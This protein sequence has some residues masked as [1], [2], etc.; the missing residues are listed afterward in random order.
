MQAV[1][2]RPVHELGC[3][4]MLNLFVLG[5]FRCLRWTRQPISTI[6]D[7][8][9]RQNCIANKYSTRQVAAQTLPAILYPLHRRRTQHMWPQA[10]PPLEELL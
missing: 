3:L 4:R 2:Q 6:S 7:S 9:R 1:W 8:W 10:R 5:L